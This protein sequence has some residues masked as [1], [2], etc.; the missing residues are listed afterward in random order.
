MAG[1]LRHNGDSERVRVRWRVGRERSGAAPGGL[2]ARAARPRAQR[3][4]E[5][6]G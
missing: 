2:P 5:A 3:R 1:F 4:Q 6:P